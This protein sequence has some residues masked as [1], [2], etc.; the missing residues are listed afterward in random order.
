[1]LTVPS[2][3]LL[4]TPP[5]YKEHSRLDGLLHYVPYQVMFHSPRR[6]FETLAVA[7]QG[8]V[9]SP[10][11]QAPIFHSIVS[12]H[13][14]FNYENANNH[15]TGSLNDIKDTEDFWMV[16]VDC[17]MDLENKYMLRVQQ[18]RLCRYN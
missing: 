10:C 6:F 1:M 4:A 14:A 15:P 17:P 18:I 11:Y 3:K 13:D 5:E 9:K 8:K 16:S 7:Q 2:I 12:H